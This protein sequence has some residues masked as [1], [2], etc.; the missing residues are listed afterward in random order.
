MS[1]KD[2]IILAAQ[3]FYGVH[4]DEHLAGDRQRLIDRCT[5]HLADLFAMSTRTAEH[6]AMQVRSEIE[7]TDEQAYIDPAS[8]TPRMV[9]LRD[10]ASNAR[11]LVTVGDLVQLVRNRAV[12]IGVDLAKDRDQTPTG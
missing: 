11:H 4:Q 2:P 9:V 6:I 7:S 1:D 5:S 10:P 8:C 3:R 12:W